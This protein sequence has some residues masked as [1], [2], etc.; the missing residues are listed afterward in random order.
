MNARPLISFDPQ[1]DDSPYTGE[2]R[3]RVVPLRPAEARIDLPDE[4]E[5]FHELLGHGEA[6]SL[7][8]RLRPAPATDLDLEPVRPG[9][10]RGLDHT[11]A[12]VLV[13]GALLVVAIAVATLVLLAAT[14]AAR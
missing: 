8:D 6:F 12:T 2:L 11:V 13:C 9:L 5:T 4:D 7:V 1:P 10:V 3:G 14:P